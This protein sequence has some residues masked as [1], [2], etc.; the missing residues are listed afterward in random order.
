MAGMAGAEGDRG[1]MGRY[2]GGRA[3]AEVLRGV[4]VLWHAVH[5]LR[6]AGD[7]V[8][9]AVGDRRAGSEWRLG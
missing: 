7:R 8:R 6:G 3:I 9:T 4:R 5:Q 1:W 2:D